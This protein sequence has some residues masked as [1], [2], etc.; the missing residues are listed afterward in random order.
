[1]RLTN[2]VIPKMEY[3]NMEYELTENCHKRSLTAGKGIPVKASKS[4]NGLIKNS[5]RQAAMTYRFNSKLIKTF[6]LVTAC[7]LYPR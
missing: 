6:A 2:A 5:I 4:S 3:L 1:M 7:A